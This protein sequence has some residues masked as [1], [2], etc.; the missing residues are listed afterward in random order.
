[1]D[2]IVGTVIVLIAFIFIGAI[3]MRFTA[4]TSDKEAELLCQNSI[5]IRARSALQVGSVNTKL[6]PALCRTVD[7][8]VSGT[9]EKVLRHIADKMA[10]CWWMF[11]EGRHEEILESLNAEGLI[12]VLSLDN[13]GPNQCFNCYTVLVGDIDGGP[14]GTEEIHEFLIKNKYPKANTNYI[15]YIQS[16]G[17]PGRIVLIAPRIFPDQA[18]TISMMPKKSS[19]SGIWGSITG[20]FGVAWTG[21]IAFFGFGIPG[22]IVGGLVAFDI[23]EEVQDYENLPPEEKIP[24]ATGKAAPV[25]ALAAVAGAQAYLTHAAYVE[26]MAKVY[27]ERDVSSIYFGFL[28]VGEKW[29]GSGDLAG[30]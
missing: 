3:L 29:C 1:M 27:Q 7:T 11:G 25:V 18:Y 19:G 8:K 21:G 20:A 6:V 22:V 30:Q 16:F 5:A 4:Q 17:G 13:A 12:G 28:Q 2:F 10:T 9:R 24:L 26:F 14:I 23:I 15:D